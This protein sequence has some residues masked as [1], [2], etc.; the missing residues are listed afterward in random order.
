MKIYLITVKPEINVTVPERDDAFNYNPK[1]NE[2]VPII[3]LDEFFLGGR[4]AHRIITD[5]TDVWVDLF[6]EMYNIDNPYRTVIRHE[7]LD[8]LSAFLFITQGPWYLAGGYG[9]EEIEI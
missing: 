9:R 4:L 7:T 3:T 1:V 5:T 8:E 2:W 6:N